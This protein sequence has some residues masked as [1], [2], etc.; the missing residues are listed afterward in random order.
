MSSAVMVLTSVVG[1][2]EG[3]VD[4]GAG[5]TAAAGGDARCHS[6]GAV[7]RGVGCLDRRPSPR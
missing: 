4:C 2:G 5:L 7:R 3:Q 1:A 6:H